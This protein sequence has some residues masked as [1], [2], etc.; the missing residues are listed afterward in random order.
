MVDIIMPAYNAHDTIVK[1]LLSIALQTYK[2]NIHL[3]I[4]DDCSKVSYEKEVEMFKDEFAITLLKL[5]KNSG[6]G[7]AR[8][9]ALERSNGKYIFF[10]DSDDLLY[11]CYAIENL[12]NEI[13]DYDLI[14]GN[15]IDENSDGNYYVYNDSKW[16]LHGKLYKRSLID[17]YNIR[18]NNSRKSEDDSFH[19][20]CMISTDKICFSDDYIYIYRNNKSSVVNSIDDYWFYSLDDY[21]DNMEW[22]FKMSEER[23][24]SLERITFFAIEVFLYTYDV[25]MKYMDREDSSRL[26]KNINKIYYFYKKYKDYYSYEEQFSVY[27]DFMFNKWPKISLEEYEEIVKN[28][29]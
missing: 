20:L 1:T 25:Y 23:N 26:L 24:L 2:S 7:Y 27:K 10:L 16:C 15:V 18:F 3:Y 28:F 9:Y 6:P 11:N 19:K 5:K 4:V 14:Q 21:I 13:G 29:C 22:L 12:V 8:E 17:K